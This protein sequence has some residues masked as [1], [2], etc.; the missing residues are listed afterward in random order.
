MGTPAAT[1][2]NYNAVPDM[3][4]PPNAGPDAQIGCQ[5]LGPCSPGT[6]SYHTD[7]RLQ[8]CRATGR[9]RAGEGAVHSEW[10]MW[11]EFIHFMLCLVLRR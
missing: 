4:L 10:G 7:E 6:T 1:Y 9:V 5:K 8:L 2:Y 3:C 11:R